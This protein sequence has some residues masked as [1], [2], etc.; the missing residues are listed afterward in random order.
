MMPDENGSTSAA[1]ESTPAP[2]AG[3]AATDPSKPEAL[4][5]GLDNQPKPPR[6]APAPGLRHTYDAKAGVWRVERDP[7][8]TEDGTPAPER[9]E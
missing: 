6:Y 5:H 4:D 2:A 9:A 3:G 8:F 1:P 7:N